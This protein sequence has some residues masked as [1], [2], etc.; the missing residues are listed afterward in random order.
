MSTNL[1]HPPRKFLIG[2]LHQIAGK[3]TMEKMIQ[4]GYDYGDIF[5]IKVLNHTLLFIN[6][7]ELAK[8]LFDETRFHKHI[9]IPIE[10]LRA[11]AKDGLFTAYDHEPNWQKAHNILTPG[12]AQRSI[13]GYVPA[14]RSI[15]EELLQKWDKIPSGEYFNFSEDMTRLTFETIGRCGFDYSFGCFDGEEQHD[16]IEAMLFALNEAVQRGRVPPFMIPLRFKQNQL[17]K[18]HLTYADGLID[19]IIQKRKKDPV[20]NAS[21]FDLL[22]LMLNARDKASSSKLSDENIRYQIYTF[23]V[24]G[25][26]T[27]SGLLS[28]AF[29]NLLT[30]PEWL[31][32]VYRE[33]DSVMGVDLNFQLTQ[34][35][36]P[37]FKLIKQVLLESLR[38]HPPVPLIDLSSDEDT[39]IGKEKYPV[40][41]G[42]SCVVWTYHLHRDKKVWGANAEQ[43]NPDNFSP[44]NVAKQ[45]KDAFKA[46]GNGKRACIGRQ[47][48]MIEATLGMAMILQ[49]YKLHLHPEYKFGLN[50]T[51]TLRPLDL[52]IRLEERTDEERYHLEPVVTATTAQEMTATIDGVVEHHTPFLVLYGSNMGSSEDLAIRIAKDARKYGFEPTLGTLDEYVDRLPENGLVQI[53]TSTYNGTPPD[54]AKQFNDWL[55]ETKEDLGAVSYCVFGCGNTQWYTYQ[56]FPSFVDRSLKR[57]GGHRF[58]KKGTADASADFEGDFEQWYVSYWKTILTLLEL[59]KTKIS[60]SIQLMKNVGRYT[61]PTNQP[62]HNTSEKVREV[63]DCFHLEED[64]FIQLGASNPIAILDLLHYQ[65]DLMQPATLKQMEILVKST[66]CPPEKIKLQQYFN[67]HD[68]EVVLKNKT[69]LD[70]LKEF[71]A[72]E[73]DFG[74]Y[75]D[76]IT[77]SL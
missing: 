4:L 62:F 74:G 57:L 21:K 71:E 40:K 15:C 13:R 73:I 26:E 19:G 7:F 10:Q 35:D 51:I 8:E 12:F 28:F 16:F 22:S 49:K 6:S 58:Y 64:L 45:D 43:F 75:L 52:K 77:T 68:T 3:D 42:Q 33:V 36:L 46:F 9:S 69:A 39:T 25:H 66:V 63:L 32:Q 41:A 24:A 38:L 59:E 2:N 27:T 61:T 47:F 55:K 70:L 31:E 20:G 60:P 17:Y 23:L 44:E 56:L 5:E 34:R 67:S 29:Y 1:P 11:I 53:I 76:M 48:A 72:C 30:H 65:V 54:N 18:K 37:K 14:M 50:Q